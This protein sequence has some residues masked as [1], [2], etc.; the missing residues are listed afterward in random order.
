MALNEK[1]G[2]NNPIGGWG[3]QGMPRLVEHVESSG[4]LTHHLI[5]ATRCGF[6]VRT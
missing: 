4:H 3:R 1:A 6:E 5:A 2:W